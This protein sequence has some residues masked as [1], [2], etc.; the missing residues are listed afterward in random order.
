MQYLSAGTGITHSEMN[1]GTERC[2]FIQVWI[3]PDRPRHTPQYGSAVLD[4]ASR[5]NRLLHL[6][7]GTSAM[8]AWP[9]VSQ[10]SATK[11]HQ[12]CNVFVSEADAGQKLECPL[13]AGRQMYA[14]CMEGSMQLN[15]LSMGKRDAAEVTTGGSDLPLAITAGRDGCHLMLIEMQQP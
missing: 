1:D 10:P 12:D 4:K 3:T 11:L 14:L 7:G 13:A 9:Q 8:P 5:H 15:E 6:L 2:R